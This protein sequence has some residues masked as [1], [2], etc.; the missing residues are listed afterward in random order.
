M[1]TPSSEQEEKRAFERAKNYRERLIGRA[2]EKWKEDSLNGK[3]STEEPTLVAEGKKEKKE[4]KGKKEKAEKGNNFC[5]KI[6][7]GF[8]L[9]E[10][11][12]AVI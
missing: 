2:L 8:H 3:F 9:F 5:I 7:R 1:I 6:T 10:A 11:V 12:E 4:K